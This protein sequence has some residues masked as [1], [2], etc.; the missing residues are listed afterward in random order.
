MRARSDIAV[1]SDS[2]RYDRSDMAYAQHAVESVRDNT[3]SDRQVGWWMTVDA[4][5]ASDTDGSQCA[6][7]CRIG[8][9]R[10]GYRYAQMYAPQQFVRLRLHGYVRHAVTWLLSDMCEGR[11]LFG[12]VGW[13]AVGYARAAYVC[14]GD[15]A[16]AVCGYKLDNGLLAQLIR[17]TGYMRSYVSVIPVDWYSSVGRLRRSYVASV[18]TAGHSDV[19]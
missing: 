7:V 4:G 8:T 19:G 16:C 10:A 18:R 2:C 9:L 14:G 3:A 1:G 11:Q 15:R 12:D 6:R 13:C 17:K 5:N